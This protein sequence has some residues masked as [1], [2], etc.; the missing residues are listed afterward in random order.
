MAAPILRFG[1]ADHACTP[2][3]ENRIR[4]LNR[5]ADDERKLNEEECFVIEHALNLDFE[6]INDDGTV[7]ACT[8]AQLIALLRARGGQIEPRA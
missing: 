1:E 4:S 5:R 8:Q 6:M 2:E 3:Q 7:L